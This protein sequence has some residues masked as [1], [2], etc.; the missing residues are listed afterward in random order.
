M[1]LIYGRTYKKIS[2]AKI[3]RYNAIGKER[4]MEMFQI[5]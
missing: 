4:L 3:M 2:A 1:G 5:V